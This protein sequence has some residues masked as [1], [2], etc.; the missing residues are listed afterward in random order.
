MLYNAYGKIKAISLNKRVLLCL[1]A[2][3]GRF[4]N[5]LISSKPNVLLI[6]LSYVN[7]LKCSL[8]SYKVK[9]A[10]V[11]PSQEK[12]KLKEHHQGMLSCK[13][14]RLPVKDYLRRMKLPGSID[15][16]TGTTNVNPTG[17]AGNNQN[18]FDP[19]VQ[20][21]LQFFHT[22]IYLESIIKLT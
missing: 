9:S 16:Y 22:S 21:E 11:S 14:Q 17:L 2:Q 20:R 12:S 5:I 3:S 1:P 19:H 6:K 8:F 4:S 10:D 15:S 7:L 18:P 13:F